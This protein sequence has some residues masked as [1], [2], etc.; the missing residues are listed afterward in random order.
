MFYEGRLHSRPALDRQ[1]IKSSSRVS[2]RG[3]RYAPIDHHGNQSSSPEEAKVTQLV[4][5]SQPRD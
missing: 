1:T 5:E 4:T 2:G 3:L